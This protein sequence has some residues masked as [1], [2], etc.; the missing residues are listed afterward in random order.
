MT[1]KPPTRIGGIHVRTVLREQPNE[2]GVAAFD[3][4]ME[5]RSKRFRI[6]GDQGVTIGGYQSELKAKAEG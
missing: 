5:Q 6:R 3:G 1:R 4:E 2:A